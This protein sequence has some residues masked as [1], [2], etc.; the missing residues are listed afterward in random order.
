MFS[1]VLFA[2]VEL[3]FCGL[4]RHE[5]H[6]RRKMTVPV[7]END[8]LRN[9]IIHILKNRMDLPDI[10]WKDLQLLTV[11]LLFC[12]LIIQVAK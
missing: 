10:E 4:D 2:Q 6:L 8:N 9:L 7:V 1:S 11:R 5:A 3:L 12:C